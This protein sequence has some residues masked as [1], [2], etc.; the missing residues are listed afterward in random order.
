M[1]FS[2]TAMSLV[3]VRKRL[4]R[5]RKRKWPTVQPFFTAPATIEVASETGPLSAILGKRV[6]VVADAQNLDLGARDLGF[7]M[8]WALLA[9]KIDAAAA[10]ASRHAILSQQ[11]GDERRMNY[12]DERDW[13]PHAT[14][15]RT[16][17]TRKGLERK[18]NADF[19]LAFLAG[20][21][22]SRASADVVVIASGDGDLVEE[23]A[24]GIRSLRKERSIVTMSLA[25]ST[26]GRLNAENNALITANIEIGKD[27]L[28]PMCRNILTEGGNIN[29][30]VKT[31][32]S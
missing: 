1:N 31:T 25:G 15:I 32:A 9:E 14:T 22:V 27:C 7:K 6:V 28:R 20:V 5:P 29:E 18:G 26:A 17:S 19:L 8:S 10:W 16:V 21:V 4:R 3:P 13:S 11:P 23:I 30:I 2:K 12:L 24:I